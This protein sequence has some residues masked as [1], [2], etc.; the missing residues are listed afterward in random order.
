MCQTKSSAEVHFPDRQILL[1]IFGF[2]VGH[3]AIAQSGQSKS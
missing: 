3:P 2:T 1:Q